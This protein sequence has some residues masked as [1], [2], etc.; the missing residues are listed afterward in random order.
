VAGLSLSE[1]AQRPDVLPFLRTA[2]DTGRSMSQETVELV[3]RNYETANSIGRTGPE[4]VDPE[5]VAPDFWA[6]LDPDF[7]L[8]ERSELP[9]ARVYRGAEEA[10]E[11]WRKTQ[12][13][14]V[15]VRWEPQEFIDLGH[16]V[17]VEARVVAVGRGSEIR[18]EMDETD[19]FWFRDG[20]IVRMQGFAT[21]AQALEAAGLRE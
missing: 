15:E 4:F 20:M 18:T 3:R 7:E 11:F 1:V 16:A 12:Q 13:V 19:V 10:K 9:D 6:R 5:E 2:R 21:K 14:F 17:V 8:H